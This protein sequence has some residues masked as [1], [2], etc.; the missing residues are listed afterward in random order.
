[1]IP[2]ILFTVNTTESQLPRIVLEYN[3]TRHS[4]VTGNIN[5]T[6]TP[7]KALVTNTKPAVMLG[8]DLTVTEIQLP[9]DITYPALSIITDNIFTIKAV[10]SK[11]YLTKN[12][13]A[14]WEPLSSVSGYAE[15]FG[16]EYKGSIY[17]ATAVNKQWRKWN[18]TMTSSA[19][20]T[21]TANDGGS[22]N[23]QYMTKRDGRVVTCTSQVVDSSK[24]YV[25]WNFPNFIAY[26]INHIS[27]TNFVYLGNNVFY[28]YQFNFS[29]LIYIP[30]TQGAPVVL[31]D[32][33][34]IYSLGIYHI[35]NKLITFDSARKCMSVADIE[36]LVDNPL[37]GLAQARLYADQ[38]ENALAQEQLFLEDTFYA[39]AQFGNRLLVSTYQGS[40]GKLTVFEL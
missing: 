6:V 32:F 33:S 22:P 18:S 27:N 40:E 37:A 4:T 39:V 38:I 35:G 3:H 7:N 20:V 17:I 30:A 5:F 19:I 15:G 28:A 21:T 36:N 13:G 31:K 14:T 24:I 9:E 25:S 23:P 8:K 12:A 26:D 16:F 10:N 34:T 2:T 11:P 1:M 29:K